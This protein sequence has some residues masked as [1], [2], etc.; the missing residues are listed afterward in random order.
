M[1]QIELDPIVLLWQILS[2]D[3]RFKNE[4]A[5]QWKEGYYGKFVLTSKSNPVFYKRLIV[6]GFD[7]VWECLTEEVE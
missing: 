6:K 7:E 5:D 1:I 2:Y 3:Y 4:N